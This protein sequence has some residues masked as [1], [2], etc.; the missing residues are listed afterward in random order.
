MS[1]EVLRQV[2]EE[3]AWVVGRT[4]RMVAHERTDSGRKG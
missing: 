3:A 4:A 1:F 2:P